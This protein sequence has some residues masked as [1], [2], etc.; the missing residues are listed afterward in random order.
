MVESANESPIVGW[1]NIARF[2]ATS[3]RSAQDRRA[4]MIEDNVLF[5]RLVGQGGKKHKIIFSYPSLLKAWLMK[6][7]QKGQ[8]L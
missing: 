5:T 8:K 6:K 1:D 2:L 7:N 3:K 4:E